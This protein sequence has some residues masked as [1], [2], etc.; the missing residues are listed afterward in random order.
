MSVLHHSEITHTTYTAKS[1]I[2]YKSPR[3]ESKFLSPLATS[4]ILLDQYMYIK[5]LAYHTAFFDNINRR[6]CNVVV[7][8]VGMGVTEVL[9]VK[10]VVLKGIPERVR[11]RECM[12]VRMQKSIV[13]CLPI[14]AMQ[15]IS[16][17]IGITSF[18]V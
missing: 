11:E 8:Q 16:L 7:F 14:R 3:Y 13:T 9:D 2:A 5:F 15:L 12:Y 4:S 10:G 6:V 1:S 18:Q 17:L